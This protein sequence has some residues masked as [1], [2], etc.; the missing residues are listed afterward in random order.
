MPGSAVRAWSYASAGRAGHRGADPVRPHEQI[1]GGR[2]ASCEPGF[3]PAVV[4]HVVTG[5]RRPGVDGEAGQQQ[6]P[7]HVPV[8]HDPPPGGAELADL[9]QPGVQGQSLD[10]GVGAD[11]V[12]QR[13]PALR[14]A[15]AQRPEP[16]RIQD[17]PVPLETRGDRGHERFDFTVAL[18]LDNLVT[19]S[20]DT[21]A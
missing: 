15:G 13:V 4:Q 19:R 16:D 20:P 5:Q 3:D 21:P 7:E 2:L 11:R 12:Q 8:D 14:Q 10:V 17:E 6:V 1:G 9:V 18:M